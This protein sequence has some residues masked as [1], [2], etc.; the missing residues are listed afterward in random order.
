MKQKEIAGILTDFL[1]NLSEE[2]FKA[3]DPLSKMDPNELVKL[4]NKI[5]KDMDPKTLAKMDAAISKKMDPNVM[6]EILAKNLNSGLNR[7]TQKPKMP[8]GTATW[9]VDCK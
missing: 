8:S 4:S 6:S 9:G 1:E 3:L 5:M 7:M 2:S